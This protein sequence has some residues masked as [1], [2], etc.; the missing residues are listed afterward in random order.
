MLISATASLPINFL[1]L[2][3]V[4]T[5]SIVLL[6]ISG[7][8]SRA[9]NNS[10]CERYFALISASDASPI[11][12]AREYLNSKLFGILN[13]LLPVSFEVSTPTISAFPI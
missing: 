10:P 2:S 3:K 9:F 13:R 11:A 8:D 5:A 12:S 7:L 1:N 6:N 4:F